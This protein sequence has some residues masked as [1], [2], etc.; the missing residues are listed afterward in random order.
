LAYIEITSNVTVNATVEATP[1]TVVS[2][3]A[4]T[5]DG[6]T[7]VKVEFYSPGVIVGASAGSFV[8]LNLWDNDATDLGRMALVAWAAT[9]SPVYAE[10]YF[11][12][13]AASKTYKIKAWRINSDGT[14]Q[15][16]TGGAGTIFPACMRITTA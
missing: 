5:F 9:Q 2:A 14:V 6:A 1:N 12:P 11:T 15:A 8:V 7:K 13:P 3:G 10:R 4:V 16:G